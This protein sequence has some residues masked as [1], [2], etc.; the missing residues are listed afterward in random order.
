MNWT[1]LLKSEL[2]GAYKSTLGLVEMAEDDQL[3]WKPA[4]G[5]NWMTMS[6][7]LMHLT[8]ACGM[9]FQ[10]FL[11][12]DWGLPE[13]VKLED[14]KPEEMLPPAEKMPAI[15]SVAKAK[16]A[17]IKD[18]Q[19][20]FDMLAIT[21]EEDLTNKFLSAPWDPRKLALGYWLLQMVN[22]LNQHKCQLFYYLKLQG[23]PVHTGHLY[24]M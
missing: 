11:T 20:A 6:Q 1:E 8:N 14:L 3:N 9:C 23:K 18:K 15:E 19:L 24:G 13:G 4:T 16:E 10:G 2:E 12:G 22:H 21:T 7:M 17:I 5:G